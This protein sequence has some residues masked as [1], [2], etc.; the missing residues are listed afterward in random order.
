MTIMVLLIR[1]NWTNNTPKCY[2][3]SPF[4]SEFSFRKILR[5]LR[6]SQFVWHMFYQWTGFMYSSVPSYKTFS[7][8]CRSL[9]AC[10]STLHSRQQNSSTCSFINWFSFLNSRSYGYFSC[11]K[12][13][14]LVQSNSPVRLYGQ[15]KLASRM[16]SV[17]T[18]PNLYLL[19]NKYNYVEVLICSIACWS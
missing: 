15:I 5:L 9:F 11:S 6:T 4:R 2:M 7:H 3:P 8:V 1:I 13:C 14:W 12:I 17:H 10:T 16:R 18:L 19:F